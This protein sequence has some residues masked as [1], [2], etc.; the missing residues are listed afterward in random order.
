MEVFLPIAQ[1]FINPIEILLLSAI[2]G[3]LS[4]FFTLASEA[5][6]PVIVPQFSQT[7]QEPIPKNATIIICKNID[8]KNFTPSLLNTAAI[9]IYRY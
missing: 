3:G 2:V 4:G 5:L 8:L 9:I 1:V 7:Y 6:F